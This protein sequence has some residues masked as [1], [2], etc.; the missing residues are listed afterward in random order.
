[1]MKLRTNILILLFFIVT[2]CQLI[3]E[4]DISEETVTLLAPYDSLVTTNAT[5]TFW[6]ENVDNAEGYN[7]QIVSPDWDAIEELILDSNISSNK[8]EVTLDPGTYAWGVSAY[9][10]FSETPYTVRVVIV[11]TSSNLSDQTVVL[12]TPSDNFSTNDTTIDFTWYTLDAAESYLFDIRYDDWDGSSVVPQEITTIAATSLIIDEEGVYVWGVKAVNDNSTSSFSK[13]TIYV[14]LT[15][16]GKPS[17]TVPAS[18]G[19]TLSIDDVTIE[20]TRPKA[21]IASVSDSLFVSTDSSF[22]DDEDE[23]ILVTADT[24]YTIDE[25]EV[26]EGEYYCRV[27]SFDAAGNIGEVSATRKFYVS[28]E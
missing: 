17:I 5:Q 23:I 7:L 11:D 25:D 21:S 19:D 6:W 27:R 1:M 10:S 16:P 13:R 24:V 22:S 3:F 28:E 20:W 26:S 15:A 8:F 9:T 4:A 14:D 18:S 2:G 12:N